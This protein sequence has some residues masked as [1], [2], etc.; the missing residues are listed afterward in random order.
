M[1]CSVTILSLPYIGMCWCHAAVLTTLLLPKSL[2][3]C[4]KLYTE[5]KVLGCVCRLYSEAN[6]MQIN[7][8]SKAL[9][10]MR[11]MRHASDGLAHPQAQQCF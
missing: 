4:S 10:L 6:S 11:L 7:R 8:S 3:E 1:E 9:M 5:A 2:D